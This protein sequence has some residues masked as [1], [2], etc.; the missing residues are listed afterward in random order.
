MSAGKYSLNSKVV[1]VSKEQ[2]EIKTVVL[3]DDS[4]DDDV[5]KTLET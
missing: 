4:D 3:D 1:K 2:P 5:K